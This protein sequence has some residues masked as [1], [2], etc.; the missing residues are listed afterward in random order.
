MALLHDLGFTLIHSDRP[1]TPEGSHLLIALRATPTLRHFDPE[2]VTLWVAA[3]GRGRATVLDRRSLP[4]APHSVL[5]GHVHVVD[6]L[7][8]ENRFLT[9]GGE[10]RAA[11]VA[12]DTAVVDLRSPGPIV[13]WGGHSQGEDP[14]AA[15]VGAFFGRLIIPIDYEPDA[16]ARVS[17]APP[18]LLYAAFLVDVT[19]RLARGRRRGEGPD[20]I[21]TWIAAEAG[22][23]RR[24]APEAWTAGE[25]LLQAIGLPVGG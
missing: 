10:L 16:E 25:T 9:F 6:R 17:A 24:V 21:A 13:R 4:R 8:V 7:E 2:G 5:W 12:T 15:E 14:L 11:A 1:W 18:L 19:A 23:V 22:R 3:S 20:P